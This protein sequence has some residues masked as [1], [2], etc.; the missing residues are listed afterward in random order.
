M[1]QPSRTDRLWGQIVSYGMIRVVAELRLASGA[2]NSSIG[3][4]ISTGSSRMWDLDV[5]K[6]VVKGQASC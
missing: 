6:A 2:T 3:F 4:R 1:S 5:A